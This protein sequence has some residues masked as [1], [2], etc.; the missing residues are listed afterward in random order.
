MSVSMENDDEIIPHSVRKF[1]IEGH[2]IV[3]AKR[4]PELD[5]LECQRLCGKVEGC[6]YFS[7]STGSEQVCQLKSGSAER[8]WKEASINPYSKTYS[9]SPM[10]HSRRTKVLLISG[11]MTPDHD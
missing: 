5:I 9:G 1:E 6:R 7:S 10:R 2:D 11:Q 8:S 3:E 4:L